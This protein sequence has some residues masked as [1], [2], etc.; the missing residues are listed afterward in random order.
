M[1][2]F[3]IQMCKFPLTQR[4]KNDILYE[5]CRGGNMFIMTFAL[6][7]GAIFETHKS[8]FSLAC[9]TCDIE[10]V[11]YVLN[12]GVPFD[13]DGLLHIESMV[14]LLNSVNLSEVR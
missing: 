1:L 2:L 8:Y 5:G 10:I 9:Q 6:K 14:T 3:L 7:C 12:Q 13:T 11:R 4:H